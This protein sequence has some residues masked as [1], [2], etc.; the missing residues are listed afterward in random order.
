[1]RLSTGIE[2]IDEL[3]GG[4]LREGSMV[5]VLGATGV[6]KTH[7]GLSFANAGLK[8]EGRRGLVLD[9]VARG[10]SQN[11][12]KYARRLFNWKIERFNGIKKENFW[13]EYENTGELLEIF[14][15]AIK[16]PSMEELSQE[17]YMEYMRNLHITLDKVLAFFY[18]GFL[19][20]R[21]RVVIDGLEPTKE[22]K[23]NLQYEVLD[24]FLR[25]IFRNSHD[26]IAREYFREKFLSYK[27]SVETHTFGKDNVA[28]VLQ[29]TSETMIEE[30]ITRKISDSGFEANATTVILMGRAFEN[31]SVKRK[32][33]I[34]KHR[35]SYCSD[36]IVDY[37]ITEKG[38]ELKL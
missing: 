15:S 27:N 37:E 30:L 25:K 29:T 9:L 8:Q 11:H 20:G 14:S 23:D 24:F 3:L 12:V 7:L 16:S 26:W 4:G 10:D 5:L 19:Q 22:F 6:G 34:A 35:G 2:A 28:M 13:E 1:M 36:E 18:A 17:D 32:L 31:N 38:I 33:Y 21:K